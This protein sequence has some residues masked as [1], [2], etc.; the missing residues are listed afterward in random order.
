MKSKKYEE[1]DKEYSYGIV[2]AARNEEKVIGNLIDSIRKQTYNQ[3]LIKIFVVSDNSTD[4]TASLCRSK[5][6]IVYERFNKEQVSKGYALEFL[7]SNIQ[8]DYGITSIDNYIIFDADNLLDK[9]YI[10]EM[11]KVI[12]FIMKMELE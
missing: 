7:F 11:N 10:Y 5:G 2:I 1:T 4:N 6:A 9:N 3:D 8:R 12:E